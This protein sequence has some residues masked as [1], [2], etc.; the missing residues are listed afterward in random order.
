LS[1]GTILTSEDIDRIARYAD[2]KYASEHKDSTGLSDSAINSALANP[3]TDEE[4][5]L[6]KK[7]NDSLAS[8]VR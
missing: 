5:A 8:E 1:D 3:A 2:A 7:F 6:L 4:L